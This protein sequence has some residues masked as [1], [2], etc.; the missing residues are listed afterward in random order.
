MADAAASTAAEIYVPEQVAKLLRDNAT[1]QDKNLCVS[2]DEDEDKKKTTVEEVCVP[3]SEQKKNVVH[4]G[5]AT[6]EVRVP[7][8]DTV[9]LVLADY[10]AAERE[11][12]HG[13]FFQSRDEVVDL[14]V[15]AVNVVVKAD[16][17]PD[18]P[19]VLRHMSKS[20]HEQASKIFAHA[21]ALKKRAEDLEEQKRLQNK[22]QWLVALGRELGA[23]RIKVTP[24][25]LADGLSR[26]RVSQAPD[27][28]PH[29]TIVYK[30]GAKLIFDRVDRAGVPEW[31]LL[32]PD[33]DPQSPRRMSTGRMH[34]RLHRRND[35]DITKNPMVVKRE[36]EAEDEAVLKTLPHSPRNQVQMDMETLLLL[37][38]A[39]VALMIGDSRGKKVTPEPM[40]PEPL[41]LPSLDEALDKLTTVVYTPVYIMDV[42]RYVPVEPVLS[43]FSV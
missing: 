28:R 33:D 12:S 6:D 35:K 29:L 21:Q 20:L 8:Q 30:N 34:T 39:H 3:G 38:R 9:D 23:E 26:R 24:R 14:R 40:G 43:A 25:W 2:N 5:A 1:E 7:E 18:A 17:P 27:A 37:Q 11:N 36:F 4:G 32:L 19:D 15:L 22:V 31:K 16:R 41:E 42:P 13:N 10:D